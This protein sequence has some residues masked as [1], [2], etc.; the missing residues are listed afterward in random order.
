M[1]F[2]FFEE[3]KIKKKLMY[4]KIYKNENKAQQVLR[5]TIL[6]ST[7]RLLIHIITNNAD[8][9]SNIFFVNSI[10]YNLI[11]FYIIFN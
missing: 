6:K 5:T 11:K 8:S 9:Q 4:I 2:C 3:G 7:N 10:E 1:C